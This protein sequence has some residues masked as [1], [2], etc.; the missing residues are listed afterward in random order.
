MPL[1][2]LGLGH[3]SGSVHCDM[4]KMLCF[5]TAWGGVF[6]TIDEM[7][8]AYVCLYLPRTEENVERYK[9]FFALSGDDFEDYKMKFLNSKPVYK[10]FEDFLNDI[11]FEEK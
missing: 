4:L 11:N 3:D 2:G 8:D 1:D 6:P 5:R 9:K 10:S 7:S